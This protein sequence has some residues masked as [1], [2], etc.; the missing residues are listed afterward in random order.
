MQHNNTHNESQQ[1]EI[2]E[3]QRSVLCCNDS[4][5]CPSLILSFKE[6]KKRL[7]QRGMSEEDFNGLIGFLKN[8]A[9]QFIDEE[10]RLLNK[11]S[12]AYGK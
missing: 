5:S 7:L 10:Y 11:Q 3:G 4:S 12:N 2:S 6:I 1:F 9:R 8:I